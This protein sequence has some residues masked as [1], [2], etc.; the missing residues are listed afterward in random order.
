MSDYPSITTQELVQLLGQPHIRIIDIR[1]VDA[2]NGWKI[3]GEKRGGHI[4]SAKSL[5]LKWTKYMDWIEIVRSKKIAT[6]HSLVIYGYEKEECIQVAKLFTKAGY[7][8]VSLYDDFIHEWSAN[9][10]LPME[11]LARYKNLVSADWVKTLLD[12]EKPPE[13]N[14]E[15]Y[16]I[17]HAHYRNREAYLSGH[18]PEA[19]D[20]DTLAL[21]SPEDWNARSPEELKKALEAHGIT[22]DTT[23]ILYGK[24]MFPDNEDDFPG[25]AA[26]HLGAIRC[27]MIMLYAGVKDVRILNG[28]YQSWI[29]EGYALSTDDLV[30]SPVANFGTE[31]P[32]FPEIIVDIDEAKNMIQAEHADIVSVRSWP[33]Y[34][35]EVS[36]YNYIENKGRIPGSVFG[37]CG[38]DAYHMENYRNVDHTIREPQEVV[39]IWK[40][41]NITPDKH[42]AFYCGTGWRGSEAFFNAWLMGWEKVAVF[43]GGWLE[44]SN[45][46]NNP[47]E[48]GIPKIK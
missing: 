32:A 12:G 21:E 47:F 35:G 23:V 5:P 18:I 43:D 36:G 41:V 37:N 16:I 22:S 4:H 48:T 11:H 3:R 9:E 24:F 15:K 40:E 1:P 27:A 39:E 8:K 6:H 13:Y 28:G 30:K 34:I 7:E 17:C 19:I 20:L 44:W 25:S 14:N 33:E 10:H 42:L 29:D 31:I 46:S 26:G 45:D 2:Y 38:T